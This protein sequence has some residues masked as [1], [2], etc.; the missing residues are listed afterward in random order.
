MKAQ[1]RLA[2]QQGQS[3]VEFNL[4]LPFLMPIV[5]VCLM[6]VV[7][8]GFIYTAKSTLDAASVEAV[9]AGTLNHGS[10]S[11]I[12][13]GLTQGLM[14]L[15]AHG[16]GLVDITK[17][18]AKARIAVGLQADIDIVS[19]DR[20]VFNRFKSRVRYPNGSIDEIPNNNLMYRSSKIYQIDND[21]KLNLQDANLL[22]IDVSWCQPLIV[23]VA[24][25]VIEN[26]VSSVWFA[27]SR[28]QLKCNALG[29]V[30]NKA[31][32]AITSSA[33]MRMQTPFRI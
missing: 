12:T 30:T 28:E 23:P 13:K 11:E 29:K 32:L 24:N 17:A 22:K 3:M 27:P 9:R 8:W 15:Y 6:L 7:Q 18:L 4:A 20:K 21:R 33:M 10:S 16:T 1:R 14:P 5:L 26:I 31:Y 19:P 25:K 2:Y